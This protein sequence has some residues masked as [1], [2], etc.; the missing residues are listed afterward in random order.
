MKS[1]RF[2]SRREF[3]TYFRGIGLASTLLPGVLWE[4]ASAQQA[5]AITRDMLRSAAAVAGLEFTDAELDSMVEGLNQTRERYAEMRA[6]PLDDDVTPPLAFVPVPPGAKLPPAKNLF[7]PSKA[8]RRDRPANLEDLAFWPVT[9]L[10][11]LVKARRV[12]SVELT[13]MYLDRLKRY[14]AKLNCVVT[15]TDDLS[16]LQAEQADWDIAA[17]RYRGPLHG[18]PWGAKDII[19]VRGYPTTWGSDAFR[20]RVIDADASVIRFMEEAGA[21]LVAKLATGE[22]ATGDQWFGGRTNNPWKIEEGSSG[23]SAGPAAATAAGLVAFGIGSETS[24]SILSPAA[25]CGVSGLRPTFG[26]VSRTGVMTLSWTLDRVGPLCRSVEDCALVLRAIARPDGEDFSVTE[27]PLDWDAS[28]DV[29]SLRVG[30]LEEGFAPADR[31]ADWK[32]NDAAALEAIRSLGITPQ[33]FRLPEMPLRLMRGI[34]GVESAA[35]FDEFIRDRHD[36]EL[37]D[38]TR[39]NGMRRDRFTPAVEY[40]Q[41][42]RI[43]SLIM[44]QLAQATS[45]FDVYL[46]PYVN[47]RAGRPPTVG[48]HTTGPDHHPLRRGEPLRLPLHRSAERLHGP[49]DSDQLHLYRPALRRGRGPRAREG[50]SGRHGLAPALPASLR[51]SCGSGFSRHSSWTI[52]AEAPSHRLLIRAGS[53]PSRARGT[54]NW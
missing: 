24:G 12:R 6:I 29:K 5:T 14:N 34:F 50:V 27:R 19:S 32:R 15:F 44:R 38:K 35:A 52:G 3:L 18:I 51:R 10:G 48:R 43:R 9:D 20:N 31:D 33:P 16:K 23:S 13:E 45:Q 21:V 49:G 1:A 8:Q 11:Q 30:Y 40:L 2:S 4:K 7:R 41:A 22:L 42:Q 26:R 25:V 17:G 53:A 39:G 47:P 28:L 36:S 46:A 54:Y 37:T